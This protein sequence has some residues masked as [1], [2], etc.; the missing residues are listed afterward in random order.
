MQLMA[1]L[2]GGRVILADHREYGRASIHIEGG[3]LFTGFDPHEETAV[4]MSHGDH[5]DVPPPGY[6]VTA[7]SKNSPIAAF[8]HQS[9]PLFGLQFHPEVAHTPRG[10]EMLQ[11]FLFGICHCTPDWTPGHFIESEI[12]KIGQLVNGRRVICGLS[13]GV[14]SSVAAA[15]VHRAVG[16]LL[17]CIFVDHG[18]LRPARAHPGRTDLPASPGH[19]PPGGGRVRPVHLPARRGDRSRGEAAPD[20][21]YLHRSLRDRSET[22]G[23]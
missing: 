4:W 10:G 8:E 15:L 18:L 19:R 11:N 23:E 17:T 13:G 9:K 22:G 3:K 20:R 1:H 12:V 16:D 6:V 14:D 2:S 21:P 5:I 7:G